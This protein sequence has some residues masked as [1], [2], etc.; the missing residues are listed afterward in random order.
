M[1]FGISFSISFALKTLQHLWSLRSNG[2][3]F[4]A[5]KSIRSK[6]AIYYL[7]G[8]T[9]FSAQQA[10]YGPLEDK[11]TGPFW[12][13]SREK[14]QVWWNVSYFAPNIMY[15][16]A[17]SRVTKSILLTACIFRSEANSENWLPN[18]EPKEQVKSN[19]LITDDHENV[20]EHPR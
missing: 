16:W 5:F 8:A 3:N 20:L 11:T 2:P 15:S 18:L 10:H 9:Y 1:F 19:R 14:N 4:G 6:I 7:T 13:R 12:F 17:W